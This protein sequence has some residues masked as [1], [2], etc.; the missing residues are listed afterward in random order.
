MLIKPTQE[1]GETYID[2]AYILSQDPSRSGYPTYTDGIKT[3]ADFTEACRRGLTR[4]NRRVLLYLEN[5]IVSGWIQFFFEE[6]SRYLQTDIF[7]ISGSIPV[8]LQE[9]SLYCEENF[10]GYTLYLGFPGENTSAVRCL[11]DEGWMCLERSWNDVL[12]FENYQLKEEKG[13]I[14]KVTREN[15]VDFRCLHQPVEG[16]MY[17]NCSR[18]LDCLDEWAIWMYY[19]RGK[20]EA[21]VYFRDEEILCEIFGV[22]FAG[23]S[24]DEEIF[25]RLVRKALN[26]CFLQGKKYMVFFNDEE[27]QRSALRLGFNCVGEYVLYVKKG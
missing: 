20:P 5:G 6:D 17:W 16:D 7:N 2:F 11:E 10:P 1:E 19:D 22:D 9:F 3:K 8:A 13:D 15:F 12:S 14:V 21:A 26:E 18:L 23:N 4:D 27:T 25:C 24:Y